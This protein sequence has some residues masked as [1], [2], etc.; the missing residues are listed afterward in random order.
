[1]QLRAKEIATVHN[2][3]YTAVPPGA[4]GKNLVFVVERGGDVR[5]IR[6]GA[7]LKQRFLSIRD[8]VGEGNE[9]GLLSIAFH[10]RYERNGRVYAYFAD[11]DDNVRVVGFERSSD[12]PL[13]VDPESM[14]D[15]ITI[16]HPRFP[17]R[18]GGTVAFGARRQHVVGAG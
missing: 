8:L 6:D 15:V 12:R 9:Q 11:V 17:A 14:K 4:A 10:P 7:L 2:P 18:N 1:L 13:R 5:I 16:P 3:V